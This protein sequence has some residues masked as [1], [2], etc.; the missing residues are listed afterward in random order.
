MSFLDLHYVKASP[1]DL[2][3]GCIIKIRVFPPNVFWQ[4]TSCIHLHVFTC[5]HLQHV[6]EAICWMSSRKPTSF[7]IE[8][9]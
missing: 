6:I 8:A 3:N 5:T 7:F 1:S 4:K 9:I 2:I